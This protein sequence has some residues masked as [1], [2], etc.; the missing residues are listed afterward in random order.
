MSSVGQIATYFDNWS[1]ITCDPWVLQCVQGYRIEFETAPHQVSWPMAPNF[2]AAQA[3]A[4]DLGVSKLL[5]KGAVTQTPHTHGEFLSNIFL[6]PKKTG[7]M[8]PVINLKPLNRH[9][10]KKK[11][12]METIGFAVQ[13][14]N[15]GD[16]MA[17]IDLKDAYFGIPIHVNDRKY[18]RFMWRDH[19]LKFVCM[20]FGYSL[21]PSSFTKA[22]KPVYSYLCM[23]GLK[24]SY[25][26][27]DTLIVAP[28]QSVRKVI[29][30]LE[31]LGYTINHE[32]SCLQ[33]T[34]EI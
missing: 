29:N 1:Q 31:F 32:K 14:I 20:L 5:E 30:L 2:T 12:K 9:V 7:D 16:Y 6:V 18:F 21:A 22:L 33:P 26:I 17:S 23:N 11:F 24:V 3:L 34:R 19:L 25:Y 28:S 13:L 4:I 10:C 27:D 8:R 15:A